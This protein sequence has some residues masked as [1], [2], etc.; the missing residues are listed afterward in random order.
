MAALRTCF[1]RG[2]DDL[3]RGRGRRCRRRRGIRWRNSR[4]WRR[5]SPIRG[6]HQRPLEC[7]E[8]LRRRH[9]KR[10]R[11]SRR[12][13]AR[14]PIGCACPLRER[15]VVGEQTLILPSFAFVDERISLR[16]RPAGRTPLGDHRRRRRCGRRRFAYATLRH[17]TLERPDPLRRGRC[18]WRGRAITGGRC[19]RCLVPSQH[20]DH[21]D[22]ERE[23][24]H[25]PRLHTTWED[26]GR[27]GAFVPNLTRCATASGTVRSRHGCGHLLS[28][29]NRCLPIAR[30]PRSITFG[31]TYIP[32]STWKFT[33]FGAPSR[34]S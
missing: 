18:G 6:L 26:A 17:L 29:A 5:W 32:F 12:H 24:R 16:S 2:T 25:D 11:A 9:G 10:C 20:N 3:R 8:I 15:D 1:F 21:D 27:D 7:R 14:Q 19:R 28:K 13:R 22:D 30:Y 34:I 31:T 4:R 33:R 23:T